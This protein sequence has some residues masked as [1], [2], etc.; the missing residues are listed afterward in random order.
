MKVEDLAIADGTVTSVCSEQG[1]LL[2]G[3]EDW[4]ERR[5]AIEFTGVVAFENYGVEGVDLSH[6]SEDDDGKLRKR[7][8]SIT[9][10]PICE[11]KCY[12]FVSGW[13]DQP[14]LRLL[15][16]ACNVSEAEGRNSGG[17]EFW[18]QYT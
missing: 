7:V 9:G 17:R 2:I 14:L 13:G 5:W 6:V 3:F 4:Q 11:A 18:G 1:R 15:A 8:S 16:E 12:T 10:E